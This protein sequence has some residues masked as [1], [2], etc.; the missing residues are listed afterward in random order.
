MRPFC[1]VVSEKSAMIF[2]TLVV[3]ISCYAHKDLARFAYYA[4]EFVF[5]VSRV[6]DPICRTCEEMP[7]N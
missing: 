5:R 2:F 1:A 3:V 7:P 4:V 6:F